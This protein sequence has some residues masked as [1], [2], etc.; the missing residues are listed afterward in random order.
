ME[1]AAEFERF[2]F[3]QRPQQRDCPD[4]YGIRFAI[5]CWF[6]KTVALSLNWASLPFTLSELQK[7][8]DF[9]ADL[10]ILPNQQTF[11]LK[12][13]LSCY[14]KTRKKDTI[15]CLLCVI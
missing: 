5:R 14:V 11:F 3:P 10:V 8:T 2:N 13:D 1:K 4:H 9:E 7:L 12:R 15:N 6:L